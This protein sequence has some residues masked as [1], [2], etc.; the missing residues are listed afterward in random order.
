MKPLDFCLSSHS[1]LVSPLTSTFSFVGTTEYFQDGAEL[2]QE[3]KSMAGIAEFNSTSVKSI[4]WSK[5]VRTTEY[6][7]FFK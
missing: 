5:P 3:L 7:I 2:W 4:L 6:W 1:W